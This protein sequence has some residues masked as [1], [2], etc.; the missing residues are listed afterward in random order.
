MDCLLHGVPR[1]HKPTLLQYIA[2]EVYSFGG[3]AILSLFFILLPNIITF[4]L[5][6][7]GRAARV[8]RV[9]PGVTCTCT[10]AVRIFFVMAIAS[11]AH[12]L[13]RATEHCYIGTDEELKARA[14]QRID[15]FG[16]RDLCALPLPYCGGR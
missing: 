7:G 6:R 14:H 13:Q 10:I 9:L 4:L 16:S 11:T 2:L 5:V 3:V 8:A 12:N 1:W 15:L